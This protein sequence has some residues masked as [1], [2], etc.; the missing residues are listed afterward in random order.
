MLGRLSFVATPSTKKKRR[1]LLLVPSILLII[2]TFTSTTHR[3]ISTTNYLELTANPG[4]CLDA[5]RTILEKVQPVTS[6][7]RSK[8]VN[9]E[10][11]K[12]NVIQLRPTASMSKKT[13]M[14][15]S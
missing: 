6:G 9:P 3:S 5:T 2:V 12:E 13:T 15:G 11:E 10:Q 4:N 1:L 7:L 14:S 8:L